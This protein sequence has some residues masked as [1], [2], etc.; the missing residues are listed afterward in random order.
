MTCARRRAT[1]C[2]RRDGRIKRLARTCTRTRQTLLLPAAALALVIG[3]PGQSCAPRGA[4]DRAIAARAKQAVNSAFHG[5]QL[6][7]IGPVPCLATCRIARARGWILLIAGSILATAAVVGPRLA[8][9]A[10]VR[11]AHIKLPIAVGLLGCSDLW[12]SRDVIYVVLLC[13]PSCASLGYHGVSHIH[14]AVSHFALC[15]RCASC[16]SQR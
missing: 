3:V 12:S 1:G 10:A 9:G 2:T 5:S 15:C 14:A 4:F 11:T 13:L 6:W 7:P 8:R 16:L